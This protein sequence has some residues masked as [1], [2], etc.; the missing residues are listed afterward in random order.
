MEAGLSLSRL[1]LAGLLAGLEEEVEQSVQWLLLEA[2]AQHRRGTD[3]KSPGQ[4]C[5][6]KTLPT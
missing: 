4:T 6:N 3:A 2:I 1:W 5:Q